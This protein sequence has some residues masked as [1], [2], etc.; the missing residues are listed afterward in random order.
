MTIDAEQIL[1]KIIRYRHI[2]D[3]RTLRSHR[4][5]WVGRSGIG[6]IG[7]HIAPARTIT[8]TGEHQR[9]IFPVVVDT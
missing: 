4:R 2:G 1:K 7:A 8:S 5:Q 9:M 3:G 6:P